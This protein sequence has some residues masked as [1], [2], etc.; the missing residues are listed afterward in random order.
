MATKTIHGVKGLYRTLNAL[1]KVAQVRIRDASVRIARFVVDDSEARARS[2]SGGVVKVARHIRYRAQRDR[3]P[4]IVMDGRATLPVAGNGW[5]HGR[6]GP[7]QTVADVMWGAEY[8]SS[9]SAQFSPWGGNGETA[10]YILWP[11]IRQDS[12]R[13]DDEYGEALLDAART[14]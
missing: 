7:R 12:D 4:K 6:S 3:V 10:G 2:A 5:T 11:V 1:P 8:G 13:I 14:A 9:K